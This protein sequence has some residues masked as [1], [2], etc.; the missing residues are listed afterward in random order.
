LVINGEMNTITVFLGNGDGTFQEGKDSGGE[1]GP[2][3]GVAQDFDGD[4]IL[5][6]AVVNIQSASLSLLYGKGDGTFHYPPRNY[7][8]PHAPFA[9]TTLTIA[10]G[11]GEQPGLAIANNA[12]S[13]VS[14]F[15]HHGLKRRARVEPESPS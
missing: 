8:T 12:S 5:D 1:A 4:K 6:V 7:P 9:L 14:I 10:T 2:N 13:N 11:R 15:L 3:H